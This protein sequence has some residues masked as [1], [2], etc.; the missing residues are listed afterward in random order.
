MDQETSSPLLAR[1]PRG[2]RTDRQFGLVYLEPPHQADDLTEIRGIATREAVILNRL[3]VY[4]FA[5]IALWRLH[6]ISA[7]ADELQISPSVIS[8]QKWI[9]QARSIIAPV[10]RSDSTGSLPASV[11]STLGMLT[12]AFLCGFLL[13]YLL[14]RGNA[15]AFNGVLSAEI[16]SLNVPVTAQLLKSHVRAGDEVFSG[17]PL[18]TL[19]NTS[20]LLSI[21]EYQV[22]LQKLQREHQQAKARAALELAWRTQEV[23]RQLTEAQA[24]VDRLQREERLRRRQA[25]ER[26]RADVPVTAEAVPK[27]AEAKGPAVSRSTM[28]SGG[29]DRKLEDSTG[30]IFFSGPSGKVSE[31]TR[32]HDEGKTSRALQDSDSASTDRVPSV[33]ALQ[34]KMAS[35]SEV[36]APAD[37]V[38]AGSSLTGPTVNED[39]TVGDEISPSELDGMLSAIVAAVGAA[40]TYLQSLSSL[41]KSLPSQVADASGI[42]QIEDEISETSQKLEELKN[43][44]AEQSVVSPAHGMVGQIQYRDGDQMQQGELLLRILHTDRRF[45]IVHVP[46]RHVNE[47]HL[48]S[49]VQLV[50][51]GGLKLRGKVTELPVFAERSAGG[52]GLA[53]VRVEPAGRLWPEVPIGTQIDV[54]PSPSGEAR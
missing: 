24:N 14:S 19:R 30:I 51:P 1:L 35:M 3:G 38:A 11:I 34:T 45:V 48:S 43:S 8:D 2:Y 50:F 47:F 20:N 25:A 49:D 41:K 26:R 10:R 22:K 13:V 44:D 9:E 7:I 46:T 33:S 6:E 16:T 17:M 54:I 27:P 37:T 39:T 52:E 21:Q 12:C 40:D 36:V 28:R 23:D 5:Q 53:A 31:F 18:F 4:C 32:L 15:T 29:P 42:K